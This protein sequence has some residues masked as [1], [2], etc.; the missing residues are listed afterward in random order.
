[1]R[2]YETVSGDTFDVVAHK[3]WGDAKRAGELMQ[4][5]FAALEFLIFPSGVILK[6]PE[7]GDISAARNQANGK[8]G[9][10]FNFRE[11]IL[12][13]GKAGAGKDSV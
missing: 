2:Q 11:V 12:G 8:A 13:T 5:N 10:A 4:A 7:G 9:D 3:I 6:V 1:L